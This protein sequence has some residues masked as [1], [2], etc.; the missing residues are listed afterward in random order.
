MVGAPQSLRQRSGGVILNVE[1]Q[2][3]GSL[4]NEGLDDGLADSAGSTGDK[5][6]LPFEAAVHSGG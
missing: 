3:A 5:N 2:D 4:Q 6:N 1:K